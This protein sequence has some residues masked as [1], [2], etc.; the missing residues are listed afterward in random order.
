MRSFSFY[1]RGLHSGS[2]HRQQNAI[3]CD[4][5]PFSQ[6]VPLLGNLVFHVGNRETAF[7]WSVHDEMCMTKCE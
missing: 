5:P 1:P 2:L 7:Q 4:A 3:D 6:T